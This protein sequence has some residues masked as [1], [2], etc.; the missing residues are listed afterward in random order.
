M[1]KRKNI[2]SERAA[3]HWNRPLR[4]VGESQTVAVFKERADVVL[5]EMV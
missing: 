3:R 4:Q 1:Y 5:R 2:F